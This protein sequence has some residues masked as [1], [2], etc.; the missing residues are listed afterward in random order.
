[1]DATTSKQVL[2]ISFKWTGEWYYA[3]WWHSADFTKELGVTKIDGDISI[4]VTAELVFIEYK[5]CKLYWI[6][7]DLKL[8]Q[9]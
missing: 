3:V 2:A 1:M 8:Q 5:L 6:H 7:F 4:S 9:I